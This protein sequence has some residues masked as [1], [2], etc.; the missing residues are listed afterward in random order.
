MSRQRSLTRVQPLRLVLAV[1]LVSC[2]ACLYGPPIDEAPVDYDTPP[3]IKL[4][5][6][7]PNIDPN[8][9]EFVFVDRSVA[10]E[11]LFVV[12]EVWDEDPVEEIAYEFQVII[13]T[14]IISLKRGTLVPKEAAQQP[15]VGTAYNGEEW[16]LNLCAEDLRNVD[17]LVFRLQLIDPVP[18]DQ[19]EA[20][21]FVEYMFLVD[22]H[23]EVEGECPTEG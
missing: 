17:W 11:Q 15:E 10:A 14:V 20:L 4:G 16:S 9:T 3:T 23:L 8:N 6:I 21:G 12:Q 2:F 7:S 22:W 19:V 18:P 1:G 13:G 5:D